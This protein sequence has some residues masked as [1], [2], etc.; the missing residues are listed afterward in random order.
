MAGKTQY[1]LHWLILSLVDSV[2]Q[3]SPSFNYPKEPTDITSSNMNPSHQPPLHATHSCLHHVYQYSIRADCSVSPA[4]IGIGC[5]L[6][7]DQ[8]IAFQRSAHHPRPTTGPPID[9]KWILE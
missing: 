8:S 3:A 6:A 4:A 9:L 2:S 7:I 1:L 5:D